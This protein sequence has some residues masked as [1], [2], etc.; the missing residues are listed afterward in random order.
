VEQKS[1]ENPCKGPLEVIEECNKE[2]CP[3]K[4]FFLTYLTNV[5][6][7]MS[8]WTSGVNFMEYFTLSS[9]KWPF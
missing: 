2:K 7:N 3:G 8:A 4:Y 9:A 6:S 5:S 1:G